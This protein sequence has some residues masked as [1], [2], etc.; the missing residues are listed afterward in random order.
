MLLV[1]ALVFFLVRTRVSLMLTLGSALA[2]VALDHAAEALVRRGV[3]RGVAVALVLLVVLLLF[4][5]MALL[6]VP[7]VMEQGRAL[8]DEAPVLWRKL[9]RSPLFSALGARSDLKSELQK[10]APAATGAVSPVL[11]AI[12]GFLSAAGG[13]LA[14]VFLAVFMLVFG[15]ELVA[16]PLSEL[17][18]G[19]RERYR[20]IAGK[21]YRS[22]GGYLAG[23]LGICAV[24]ATL[25]TIALA[26]AGLPFFLPLGILSGTSSLVPYAGPLVAGA[27]ITLLALVTGGLWKAVAIAAYFILYGQL[28]GNVLGPLVYRRTVHV[29][30]LVTLLAILFLAEFMGVMGAVVA[31]PAAAAAQIVVRELLEMR[32]E[33]LVGTPGALPPPPVSS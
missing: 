16:A 8:L 24:N 20:R 17:P 7:P 9:Q 32:R 13:L 25:T 4:V 6:L 28:E 18:P 22:V 27:S 21:I 30:P 33:R 14:F 10:A 29:N 26:V 3:R 1:A 31:V 23:L 12:G 19:T 11:S 2:A 15:R 5:G